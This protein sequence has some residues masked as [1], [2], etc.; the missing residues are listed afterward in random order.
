MH[1]DWK[2]KRAAPVALLVLI[3]AGCGGG[4]VGHTFTPASFLLPGLMK[5]EPRT[6]IQPDMFPAPQVTLTNNI[7]AQLK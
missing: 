6:P 7:V 5:A 1:F 2:I 3:G 4:T